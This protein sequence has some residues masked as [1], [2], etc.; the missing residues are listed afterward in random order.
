[1]YF[2][3]NRI[4]TC[5]DLANLNENKRRQVLQ[6]LNDAEYNDVIFVLKSMPKLNI[7]PRFE[8]K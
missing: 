3:Q 5:A 4:I 8:G 6:L 7:E 1:M 2:F